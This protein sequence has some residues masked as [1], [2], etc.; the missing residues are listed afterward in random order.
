MDEKKYLEDLSPASF[1][2]QDWKDI[3]EL[4][5]RNPEKFRAMFRNKETATI[6]ER[7]IEKFLDGVKRDIEIDKSMQ[8]LD[9][10]GAPEHVKNFWLGMAYAADELEEQKTY[11][12]NAER[13]LE[14]DVFWNKL[15]DMFDMREEYKIQKG[16]END[17]F[18]E[19]YLGAE[20]KP[21]VFKR[22]RRKGSNWERITLSFD[23]ESVAVDLMDFQDYTGVLPDIV[24]VSRNRMFD[25]NFDFIDAYAETEPQ[26]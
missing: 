10:A 19:Q 4:R 25:V 1:T 24:S 9:E 12:P 17:P 2:E 16:D 6:A 18:S 11:T 14:I 26:N 22:K 20:Y 15:H 5:E 8:L 3:F 7:N 23:T 13:M 21:P